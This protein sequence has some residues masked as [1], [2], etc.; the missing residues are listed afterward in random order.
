VIDLGFEIGSGE[1]VSVP[2]GHTIVTGQSQRSGKTT[3]LEAMAARA[4]MS[5]IAFV[6]KRGESSFAASVDSASMSPFFRE[7]ADWR[8]V[9]ATLQSAF[10]EKFKFER[11]WIVRACKGARTLADVRA[12]AAE[13]ADKSKRS[14]DRDVYMMIGEYLDEVLPD[15]H[16]L[17]SGSDRF[18][19]SPGRVNIMD[20]TSWRD[21]MQ[22]LF[23]ASTLDHVAREED[24]V[25]VVVPESWE[26]LPE[27][28]NT[29]VK[30]PAI[31]IARKGAAVGN[32]LWLD[33]QDIAGVSKEI[34]RQS[35][36]WLLGVQREANEIK[37]TLNHIP[38]G[39]KKPKADDIAR[40]ELGQFF[41]C[42]PDAVKKIYVQPVWMPGDVAHKI[43]IGQYN[44]T[45][46]SVPRAAR[47]AAPAPAP[48]DT[49]RPP[50]ATMDSMTL[51][52]LRDE[53]IG[54]LDAQQVAL[55]KVEER[56]GMLMR[57]DWPV[58]LPPGTPLPTRQVI[59]TASNGKGGARSNVPMPGVRG[60]VREK[61]RT[62]VGDNVETLALMR[63][64]RTTPKTE[65]HD[66]KG[67]S[68]VDEELYQKFKSRFIEE[69]RDEAPK[70]LQ[71][72]VASPKIELDIVRETVRVDGKTPFGRVARLVRDGWF[73]TYRTSNGASAELNSTG[74]G[75]DRKTVYNAMEKLLEMGFLLK[76]SN[77][78]KARPEAKG[79]LS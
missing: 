23:I 53:I 68:K 22:I 44:V 24:G 52:I 3:A 34:I 73:D 29:P 37:R 30:D 6:T 65:T 38:A 59:S 78:Y 36:V 57:G 10:G 9:E 77:G 16:N 4:K 1:K 45:D 35:S 51:R 5:V 61:I 27:R 8:F 55:A 25:V 19:F 74:A 40:L 66:A 63:G 49:R 47:R 32:F 79:N 31:Q 76:N 13:F 33:S 43:A 18:L 41:A 15:I 12:A 60:E 20:L 67:W 42:T 58:F 72:V 54:R 21:K 71:V 70:I 75:V 48:A 46:V 56:V 50:A 28:R 14:M 7:R 11:A 2:L 26:T 17:P 69:L 62:G 39:L 64:V